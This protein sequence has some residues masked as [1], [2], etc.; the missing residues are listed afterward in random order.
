[1]CV[2]ESDHDVARLSEP[3]YKIKHNDIHIHV[4]TTNTSGFTKRQMKKMISDSWKADRSVKQGRGY[5]D[6]AKI[7]DDEH[8]IATVWYLHKTFGEEMSFER[9]SVQRL[10]K[11][12]QMPVAL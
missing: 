12:K 3:N 7:R 5:F 10:P 8:R 6:F 2:I 4:L 9:F 1:M 11:I